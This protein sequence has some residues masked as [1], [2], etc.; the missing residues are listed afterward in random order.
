V[1]PCV[2]LPTGANNAVYYYTVLDTRLLY[3]NDM[4]GKAKRVKLTVERAMKA[5]GRS[6]DIALLFL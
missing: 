2:D 1:D 4:R 3:N 6:R 5:Q